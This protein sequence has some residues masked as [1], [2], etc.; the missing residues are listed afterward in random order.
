MGLIVFVFISSKPRINNNETKRS[1]TRFST[2]N[3]RFKS[4][5]SYRLIEFVLEDSPTRLD[6]AKTI[7]RG[8]WRDCVS[9]CCSWRCGDVT[10]A[11]GKMDVIALKTWKYGN[12]L[13]CWLSLNA[14]ETGGEG[15]KV[16]GRVVLCLCLVFES[17]SEVSLS[18][19]P[20][21]PDRLITLPPLF[22][23]T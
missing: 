15:G 21:N 5:R 22:K 12:D 14:A 17:Q 19:D 3:N 1:L 8:C 23:I 2:R 16:W 20:P 13:W 11:A 7:K 9:P 10:L 18:K 4:T 6:I